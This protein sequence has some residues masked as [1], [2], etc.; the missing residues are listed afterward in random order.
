MPDAIALAYGDSTV[1]GS[2]KAVVFL[3]GGLDQQEDDLNGDVVMGPR[4][5]KGLNSKMSESEL[6]TFMLDA[7]NVLED[8]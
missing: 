8:D 1:L 2:T 4:S 7:G 5:N 3:E 6:S